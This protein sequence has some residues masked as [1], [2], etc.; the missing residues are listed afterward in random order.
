LKKTT[1]LILQTNFP[2]IVFNEFLTLLKN[3]ILLQYPI[4]K[5][6]CFGN[7]PK[8]KKYKTR[9]FRMK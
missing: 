5:F 3:A 6:N 4:S 7:L 2:N 8:I 1:E 9:N